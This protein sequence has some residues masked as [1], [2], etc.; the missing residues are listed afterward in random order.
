[1]RLFVALEIP[2]EW[3]D[4]ARI[5]TDVIAQSTAVK[6]RRVDPALMHITLRFLGEVAEETVP[7]LIAALRRR[8]AQVEVTLRLGSPNT[9]GP[10]DR[11]RT[12]LFTVG[13]DTNR[14][15]A[16]A[17]LVEMAVRDAGLPPEDR[18]LQ[19]HLTLARLGTAITP[20]E[21]RAVAE[22]A[23]MLPPLPTHPFRARRIVLV[24]SSLG[25]AQPRYEV[26]ASF[27]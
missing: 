3:R 17:R 8:I 6:L 26:I 5:T 1:M 15:R 23:R 11:T 21:R 7:V 19:P 22:T 18:A 2:E 9:F 12:L 4:A 10:L 25:G 14:L 13:G 20:E 27:G 16:L 24:R